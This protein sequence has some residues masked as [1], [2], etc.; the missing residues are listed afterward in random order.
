M[1][2]YLGQQEGQWGFCPLHDI[3]LHFTIV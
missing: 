1:R 3:W 2:A